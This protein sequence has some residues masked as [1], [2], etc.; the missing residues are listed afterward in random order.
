MEREVASP[1]EVEESASPGTKA[2]STTDS[3][4]GLGRALTG[5]SG[6]GRPFLPRR[7]SLAAPIRSTLPA[8]KS[9]DADASGLR[10]GRQARLSFGL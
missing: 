2:G 9:G 5:R 1:G 10:D 6:L 4:R 8:P 3:A 7:L